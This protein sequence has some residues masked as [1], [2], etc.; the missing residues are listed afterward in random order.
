MINIP[1]LKT[2][3][4]NRYHAD[5]TPLENGESGIYNIVDDA[6]A[7]VADWLPAYADTLGAKR[8]MRVPRW[9]ARLLVGPYAIYLMC[10]QQGAA[11]AKAKQLLGWSPQY[12][13]WRSGFKTTTW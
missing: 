8:P 3:E 13:T 10:E 6:P 5:C 7:Q 1:A 2:P 9:L 11:N 12:S 4:K